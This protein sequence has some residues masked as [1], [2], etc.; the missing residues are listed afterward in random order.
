MAADEKR[1]AGMERRRRAQGVKADGLQAALEALD[2]TM[3]RWAHEFVFGEVWAGEALEHRDRMLV[4]IA[5]LAATTR[6]NQLK[7]Y[8]HGALQSGIKEDEL[9]E[10]MKMLTVYV[11]FPGAI[12]AMLQLDAVL[13]VHRRSR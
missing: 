9:R 12:E 6:L 2:P 7:N 1:L 4:A 11:G 13:A 10:V 8:L 3:G 5:M